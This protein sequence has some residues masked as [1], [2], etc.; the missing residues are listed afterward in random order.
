MKAK[1]AFVAFLVGLLISL[2]GAIFKIEHWSGGDLLLLTGLT[3][4]LSGAVVF[5]HKLLTH[6]G[7]KGFFNR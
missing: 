7:S 4:Q 1:H 3:L 5:L 6:P 2:T